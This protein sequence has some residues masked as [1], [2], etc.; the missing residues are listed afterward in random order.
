MT[1]IALTFWG[2][3]GQVTGSYHLLEWRGHRVHG[4]D[5]VTMAGVVKRKAVWFALVIGKELLQL[6][7]CW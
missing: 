6:S 1:D 5:G 3:A 2:A 4:A 7:G